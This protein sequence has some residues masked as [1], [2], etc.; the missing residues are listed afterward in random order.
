[1]THPLTTPPSALAQPSP[2]PPGTSPLQFVRNGRVQGL[3]N[4]PPGRTLLDMLRNDLGLTGTKEGCRSGDCGACTVVLAQPGPDGQLHYRAVNSCIQLAHAVQG[5]ALWTV[6]DLASG[7]RPHPVQQALV[8]HHAS[9]CGFC[10]PGFAMSL[11]ALYQTRLAEAAKLNTPPRS[12]TREDALQALS[13]NLCR[14][15]GYR[16]ILDAA[17]HMMNHALQTVDEPQLLEKLKLLHRTNQASEDDFA[18]HPT[19]TGY[20]QPLRLD[21]LLQLRAQ[22]PTAQLVAGCTDVGLWV[23]KQHQVPAQV[24]DV[25]RVADLLQVATEPPPSALSGCAG[26]AG[27]AAGNWLSIGAAV[28][29]TDAFDALVATRPVLATFASR[30][31]GLPVRNA[32]TLGGNVANGSPIGDS[33]PLLLALGAWVRLMRA[34]ADTPAGDQPM[35][36][37]SQPCIHARELPLEQFYTG[38][39]QT[40]LRPDEVLTHIL[41]PPAGRALVTHADAASLSGEFLRAYK[42]SKR[43]EDD[44]SAVCLGLRIVLRDG[45]VAEARLGVGGVAATP[46][47]ARQTEAALQGRTWNPATVQQA[48]DVLQA[49]FAP[50]SD[51]RASAAYRR[52]ALAALLQRAWAEST[53]SA[54]T[55]LEHSSLAALTGA[56]A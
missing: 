34:D 45:V 48:A 5:Q 44:I 30:F 7:K 38:Y 12:V 18:S 49:E 16:P 27:D 26:P 32:G 25:T 21:K 24:L 29:L 15:T 31:A 40:A 2:Q 56:V 13:G 51:M 4:V 33:M 3:G 35:P 41:V 46:V 37:D 1:M 39:R 19:H 6:D 53:G 36:T 52:T 14:C 8:Q 42:L 22:H 28:T 23:T 10:T 47:R 11:F 55:N 43:F 17:Q 20:H 50:I 54:H 9:Q